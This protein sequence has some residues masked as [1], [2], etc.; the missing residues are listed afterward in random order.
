[1][2]QE[3]DFIIGSRPRRYVGEAQPPA[4]PPRCDEQP[5]VT[6]VGYYTCPKCG[7]RSYWNSPRRSSGA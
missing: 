4:S 3:P 2:K 5:S 1:M 7:E 6:P